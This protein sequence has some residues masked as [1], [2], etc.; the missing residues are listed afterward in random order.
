MRG[1]DTVEDRRPL[2]FF[3]S[4]TAVLLLEYNALFHLQPCT[5]ERGTER[6]EDEGEEGTALPVTSVSQSDLIRP[7]LVS[8]PL[9]SSSPCLHCPARAW[10]APPLC[11]S[12]Y[13][14][15]EHSRRESLFPFRPWGAHSH[16]MARKQHLALMKVLVIKIVLGSRFSAN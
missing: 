1:T 15:E 16:P 9:L 11:I 6:R 2:L 5:R 4:S 3:A 10:G 13:Q 14:P 8:S 7:S 12:C